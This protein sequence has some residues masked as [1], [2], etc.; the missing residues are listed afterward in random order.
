VEGVEI[1]QKFGNRE[2][3]EVRSQLTELTKVFKTLIDSAKVQQ[4][5]GEPKYIS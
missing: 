1:S 4:D 3:V 5:S 2:L